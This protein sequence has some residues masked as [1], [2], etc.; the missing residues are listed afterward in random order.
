MPKK[1]K[2][3]KEAAEGA[4]VLDV[5]ESWLRNQPVKPV[6]AKS[7]FVSTDETEGSG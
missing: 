4:N 1:K 6:R 2:K 5:Y 3:R 7:G